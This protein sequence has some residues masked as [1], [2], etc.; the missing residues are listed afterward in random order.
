M[1]KLILAINPGSTSTK[2]GIYEGVNEVTRQNISHSA[3]ELNSYSSITDQYEFRLEK[4]KK[5]LMTQNLNLKDFSAI[6]GR[7]GLLK[8]VPSGTYLVN[9]V[10]LQDLRD[11]RYGSHASN[12]GAILA[13]ALAKE[14]GC[15][16]FIVDPVVVDELT[17]IARVTGRPEIQKRSVFHALNQ[18]A[19][20]KRYAKSINKSYETLR[21]IV[22]H[23]GG[24]IS[25]GSH[26]AGQV[27]EVNNAIDGAGAFSPERS[28]TM[29]AG[30]LAELILDQQ[31]SRKEIAKMLA[32][33]G[34]LVAHLGT[35]DLVEVERR[36]EMGDK[37]V[38]L[39]YNAMI[40]NIARDIA[41]AAVPLKGNVDCILLTGGMAH[42]NYL[43][44]CIKE[45]VGFIAPIEV[46]P[47]EDELQALSEGTYRVLEGMETAK[48][49][50]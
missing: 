15:S 30:Q 13:D 48:S 12:L 1:S 7:G 10:M 47:G 24:G 46:F 3:E 49:Y 36:S 21:V 14:S 23:M 35:N 17:A 31:L 38:E 43:T 27:V 37:Q 16:A 41:A 45:Y 2:I 29:P 6:V 5:M 44:A 28:G 34:G 33:Q 22:C 20:A 11:A 25:V 32:G 26:Q 8:P 40:Y 50:A 42:S 9:K 39:I 4:I 19:V 18:K